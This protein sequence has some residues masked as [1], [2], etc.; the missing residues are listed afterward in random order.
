MAKMFSRLKFSLVNCTYQMPSKNVVLLVDHRDRDLKGCALIAHHLETMSIRVHLEPINAWQAVLGAHRPDFI[1]F[2]HT[3]REHLANYTQHLA[4]MG[5]LTGVLPNEGLLYND[6]VRGYNSQRLPNL[7]LDYYFCWNDLH[8]NCLLANGFE[9]QTEIITV[10]VPRFDFYFEPWKNIFKLRAREPNSRPR[11]LLCTNFGYAEWRDRPA[12]DTDRFFSQWSHMPGYADYRNAIE[13]SHRSRLRF[14][15]F[16]KAILSSGKFEV[17]LK[18]H[19][20]ESRRTYETWIANLS[21]ELQKDLTYVPSDTNITPQILDSDLEISCEKC[22]TAMES[23][24]ARKPTIELIF[25]KHPLFFDAALSALNSA[26]SSPDQIVAQIERELADPGQTR[27]DNGRK[28][29]LAKW[30]HS[31]DGHAAANVASA[32]A[33]ALEK[34]KVKKKIRLN[35]DDYRRA[36]K[37]KAYQSIGQ[38]YTFF[39]LQQIKRQFLGGKKYS[40]KMLLYDKSVRPGEVKRLLR[41]LRELA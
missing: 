18:T 35:L 20:R 24:I 21:S 41:R 6:H 23:W 32:V 40:K 34:R 8:R 22:T 36:L 14:L 25:E 7:H 37:L 38:P 16:L 3:N 28:A 10:G 31:P 1:L 26:C 27:F 12:A 9:G 2:N 29:H 4:Q 13:V 39:P 30:C 15:D 5:V 17:V 19:P 33:Q 11:I